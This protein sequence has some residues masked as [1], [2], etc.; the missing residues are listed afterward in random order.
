V[1]ALAVLSS[2]S[3]KPLHYISL[4]FAHEF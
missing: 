4:D 3:M 2:D 1:Q